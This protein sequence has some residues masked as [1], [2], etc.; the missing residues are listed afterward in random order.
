MNV[1]HG[2]WKCVTE[3]AT[4]QSHEARET[5]EAGA[6]LPQFRNERLVVRITRLVL[7][8]RDDYS[9]NSALARKRQPGSFRLI[10]NHHGD[11]RREFAGV[12]RISDRL[13]IT[14]APGD[15][16]S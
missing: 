6:A 12:D 14:P 7:P 13:Q 9:R 2:V 16:N 10:R 1:Q 15:Q 11:H 5:H 8:V 3:R 4:E